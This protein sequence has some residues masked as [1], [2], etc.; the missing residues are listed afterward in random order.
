MQ[1][2]CSVAE[3]LV[4]QYCKCLTVED[5]CMLTDIGSLSVCKQKCVLLDLLFVITSNAL[6]TIKAHPRTI[7][8]DNE[9]RVM[10]SYKRCQ[11]ARERQG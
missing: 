7:K 1:N 10:M 9:N 4:P 11:E 3:F 5:K 2:I 8:S 6:S